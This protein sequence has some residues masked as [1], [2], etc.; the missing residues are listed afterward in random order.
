MSIVP[1]VLRARQVSTPL[2]AITTADQLAC[3]ATLTE[4][5]DAD[6]PVISYDV[7]RGFV[8]VND[9]GL[10]AVTRVCPEGMNNLAA[11]DPAFAMKC[12]A[13]LDPYGVL[14]FYNAH[15]WVAEPRVAQGIALLRNVYKENTRDESAAAAGERCDGVR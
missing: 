13:E 9:R 12:A 6:Y 5:I 4:A 2:L 11:E 10:M 7:T 15:C 8:G 1:D 3:V 14:F